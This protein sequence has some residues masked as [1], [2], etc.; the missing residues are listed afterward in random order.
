M[1]QA[2]LFMIVFVRTSMIF[3]TAIFFNNRSI[4]APV[5]AALILIISFLLF[6]VLPTA[7]WIIPGELPGFLIFLLQEM[8]VGILIG[9][10][11]V[12]LFMAIELAGRL[13]SFQMS[14]SMASTFDPTFGEQIDLV[15][16]FLVFF[17]TLIFLLL[18]GDHL[19]L[20]TLAISFVM[21]PPGQVATG[22]NLIQ[23]LIKLLNNAFLTGFKLASPA[24]VILLLVDLVLGIVGKASSKMQIFFLGMPLKVAVGLFCITGVLGFIITVWGR[25]VSHLPEAMSQ[26]LELARR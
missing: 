16:A 21:L 9:Y 13:L 24:I 15:G 20:K 14:F 23:L 2:P 8:V 19:V 10:A 6:P 25:D 5:K 26:M 11:I 7:N 3:A 4:I 1:T 18:G 12:I 17:S 22:G